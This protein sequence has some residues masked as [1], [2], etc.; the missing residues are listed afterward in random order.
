VRALAVYVHQ[1]G[2]GEKTPVVET[3]PA[4][5]DAQPT[6]PAGKAEPK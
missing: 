5:D 1:L 3:Q 4:A 2:G 6:P